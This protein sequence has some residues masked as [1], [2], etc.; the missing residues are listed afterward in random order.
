[1]GVLVR[2]GPEAP[3]WLLIFDFSGQTLEKTTPVSLVDSATANT[4]NIRALTETPGEERGTALL[5]PCHRK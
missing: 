2:G 1:M 4:V 5:R 3:P